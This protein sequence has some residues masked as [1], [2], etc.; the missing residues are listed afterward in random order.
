MI[1][2]RTYS[3]QGNRE[4]NEDYVG[5]KQEQGVSCFVLAD[6]L[7]GHGKGEV[8]SQIAVESALAAFQ[9]SGDLEHVVADTIQS[10]QDAVI[11][12]QRTDRSLYDMKTTLVSCIVTPDYIQWGHVGDSRLYYFEGHKL[13][14][15]TL[16]HSVPQL[17]AL[18]KEIRDKD[19]RNHPDRNRLLRVIGTPWEEPRYE[20]S[21]CIPLSNKK[22]QAILMCTDGFWELIWITTLQSVYTLNRFDKRKHI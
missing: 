5:T 10:A 7:G 15:R 17:M 13:I 2:Y 16:D 19:I 3:D 4:N 1:H 22:R 18:A 12:A 21:E 14:K 11:T 6:G 8:A 9:K 20:V